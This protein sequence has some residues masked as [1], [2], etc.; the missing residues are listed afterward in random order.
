M[1]TDIY[2]GIEFRH[3]HHDTDFYDGES[4]VRAVDLWPLLTGGGPAGAYP[5]FAFLF[6]ARNTYG[7]TPV[8]E[9]R[10][11]PDDVSSAVRGELGPGLATGELAASWV[12]W[13]ELAVLDLDGPF[14]PFVAWVTGTQS[15]CSHRV[16]LVRAG[17]TPEDLAHC[18]PPADLAARVLDGPVDWTRHGR[19]WTF[20]PMTL[21]T[22]LGPG[23]PWGHV[24][25]VMRA[26]AARYGPDDVRLVAAFD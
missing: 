17:W 7:F 19:T 5:A 20:T 2:G 4:W 22:Y 1:V 3:P 14:G 6:G 11:L 26:L 15:G 23:T 12:A 24:L 10:G 9:G 13:S 18:E 21:G 8:A 16:E 25:A